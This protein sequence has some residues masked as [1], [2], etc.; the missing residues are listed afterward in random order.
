MIIA[1]VIAEYN[2]F[3]NGHLHHLRET[4]RKSGCDGLI[5]CLGG[6]FT[7]GQTGHAL[8]VDARARRFW[9]GA[10]AVF[11]LP[12]PFAVRTADFFARGG[13]GVLAGLHCDVL[14]FGC[15]TED[16]KLLQT[17]AELRET[18]RRRFQASCARAWRRA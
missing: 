12:A 15:E 10:D 11:E 13:V 7:Q 18:G 16:V 3:H 1:G 17:L 6:N 5:V 8:Q 2:P 4:R 9:R 14:S